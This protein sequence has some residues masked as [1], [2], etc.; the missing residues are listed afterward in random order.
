M[1]SRFAIADP[2]LRDT[3]GHH[4]A[5]STRIAESARIAGLSP[6]W[7][8]HRSA[9]FPDSNELAIAPIFSVSMYDAYEKNRKPQA[10]AAW[11]D[12][13][14][15]IGSWLAAKRKPQ[16]KVPHEALAADIREG[17]ARLKLTNRDRM[18]FHT[19]DGHTYAALHLLLSDDR[20]ESLPVFHVCTPYDP[21]GVMPNRVADMPIV[22]SVTAWK[23]R[24]MIG[25]RLF[26]YGENERLSAHIANVWK[27]RV[28]ALPLPAVDAP[29]TTPDMVTK[30]WD[31]AAESGTLKIVHLGPARLE[32]GFHLIPDIVAEALRVL[33][34]DGI[35]AKAEPLRFV[36]QATPQIVGYNPQVLKAI[37]RLRSFGDTVRLITDTLD[38]KT[39]AELTATS[40]VVLMP[41]GQKEYAYRS[42]GVVSE[43][44]SM[45][46]IIVAT[47]NTYPASMIAEDSGLTASTAM[48]F[49]RAIARIYEERDAFR[50]GAVRQGALYRSNCAPNRYVERCLEA[51]ASG[52]KG[53]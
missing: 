40:D 25:R 46:K 8:C 26:L 33:E 15:M 13:L 35:P 34:A 49:G 4:H 42:S 51:E 52:S 53:A 47:A 10:D 2:S 17:A 12:R 18:L 38:D 30:H 21:V 31:R 14:P 19:A 48:E 7:I 20:A 37:D 29:V 32:K 1:G 41:Y 11:S 5:L 28:D 44:L 22:H 36:I 23:A 50:A 9:S 3:R 45:D 43:A 24:N 27:T 39:Y 6:A 16:S